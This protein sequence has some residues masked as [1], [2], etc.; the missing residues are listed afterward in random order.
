MVHVLY[1]IYSEFVFFHSD[2][3]DY[4]YFGEG[5]GPILLDEV[6]CSGNE[7]SISQCYH[8]DIGSHDCEHTFDV[9]I[10]CN[11]VD[12]D[13]RLVNGS[14]SSE[15]RVEYCNNGVWGTVCSDIWDRKDALVVCRQ[16]ELSTEC[17]YIRKY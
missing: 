7:T 10:I 3:T 2:I 17:K 8:Q 5:T 1:I 14:N 4:N 12:G 11:C 13:L 9:G 6:Q 15:G 16:L